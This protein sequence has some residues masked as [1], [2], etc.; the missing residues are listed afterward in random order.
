MA[1]NDQKVIQALQAHSEV[2]RGTLVYVYAFQD[3][4]AGLFAAL[5]IKFFYLAWDGSKFSLMQISLGGKEKNFI[6][7]DRQDIESV[8]IKNRIIDIKI[9]LILKDKSI[10]NLKCVKKVRGLTR[11]AEYLERI[12]SILQPYNTT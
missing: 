2:Q 10:Y 7:F 5:F 12:C 4:W 6:S 9:R 3:D 11:Q 1:I 8:K